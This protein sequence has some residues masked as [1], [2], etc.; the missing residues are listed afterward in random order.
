MGAFDACR[1]VR[2]SKIRSARCQQT[3]RESG[4]MVGNVGNDEV[5]CFDSCDWSQAKIEQRMSRRANSRPRESVV[6]AGIQ[7]LTE[8]GG[9]WN[10]LRSSHHAC[11]PP[12]ANRMPCSVVSLSMSCTIQPSSD[13]FPRCCPFLVAAADVEGSIAFNDV[14]LGETRDMD[15]SMT[16]SLQP[17]SYRYQGAQA[18][19]GGVGQRAILS[20]RPEERQIHSVSTQTP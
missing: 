10:N 15:E 3:W 8:L 1:W 11:Y 5:V 4:R 12:P 20:Q 6:V 16:W 7:A 9:D 2:L 13:R 19:K 17:E 14:C 18:N